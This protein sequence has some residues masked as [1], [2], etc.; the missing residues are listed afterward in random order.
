M[1]AP[2]VRFRL[3]LELVFQPETDDT[4]TGD[5]GICV[6]EIDRR[7]FVC[8]L[9]GVAEEADGR[10]I[11]TQRIS[12]VWMVKRVEHFRTDNKLVP[13]AMQVDCALQAKRPILSSRNC[14]SI[15]TQSAETSICSRNQP[16]NIV[17]SNG[18]SGG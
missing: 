10:K 1:A 2:S 3:G 13:L 8:R 5:G 9:R 18:R 15:S 12:A 14:K 16:V 6:E 7:Y 4:C 17:Q 11:R